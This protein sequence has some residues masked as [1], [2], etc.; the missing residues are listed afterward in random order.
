LRKRV[1]TTKDKK[2]KREGQGE[3]TKGENKTDY[4]DTSQNNTLRK[5]FPRPFPHIFL[6]PQNNNNNNNKQTNEQT[7]KPFPTSSF[8]II[9]PSNKK[10]QGRGYTVK[11]LTIALPY[12]RRLSVEVNC[13]HEAGPQGDRSFDT[14]V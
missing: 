13:R 5:Q 12:K 4:N 9:W 1:K 8:M 3:S 11:S 6:C 14:D 2:K 7:R 10:L